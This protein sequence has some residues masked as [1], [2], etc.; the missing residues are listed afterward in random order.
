[1]KVFGENEIATTIE[2]NRAKYDSW[3]KNKTNQQNIDFIFY[4]KHLHFLIS[5]FMMATHIL[6]RCECLRRMLVSTI[7]P[8]FLN[9][10][11]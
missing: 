10:F 3:A 8:T 2:Y 1:M 9:T 4:A 7:K 11:S 5:I 6:H